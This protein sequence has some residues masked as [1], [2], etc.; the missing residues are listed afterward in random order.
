MLDLIYNPNAW[1]ALLALTAMEIVLGIDNIIFISLLVSK[2]KEN[3]AKHARQLGLA[4]ALIFRIIL[5]YF[6]TWLI[7]LTEP[8]IKIREFDLSWR[9]IV[10]ILGGLFLIVKATRE[11]HDEIEGEK[12]ARTASRAREA[13]F[14]V[15]V[16]VTLI[17]IVFSV[18]SIIT[19]I[20][21]ADDIEVMVA[22][23]V[24][25][26]I[27]M[28][29]AS[30]FVSDFIKKYPTVK[31]L[32]LAFLVLIGVSLVADG[33]GFHIPRGYIYFSMAFAAGVEFINVMVKRNNRKTS[34]KLPASKPK[35]RRRAAARAR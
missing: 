15:I 7:G 11:I 31:M 2:L 34:L 9:D 33:F 30:G 12:H 16:Q 19:A 3:A 24:I 23:V 28:Y 26:M 17:D 4:M 21:M 10:L 29:L 25:A 13:F 32:A 6:L 35:V 20:G 1:A 18:D 8:V 5:L 14:W 27:V 22:A